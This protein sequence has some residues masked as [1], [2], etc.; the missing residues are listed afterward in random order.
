MV[1]AGLPAETCEGGEIEE[2]DFAVRSGDDGDIG[3]N[4]G[5]SRIDFGEHGAGGEGGH[6]GDIAPEIFLLNESGSAQEQTKAMDLF[7]CPENGFVL[8]I[9]AF[10][11][12]HA[13]HHMVNLIFGYAQ[14]EI[15]FF[16]YGKIF[17]IFDHDLVSYVIICFLNY[18]PITTTKTL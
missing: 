5:Q 17:F 9:G 11:R 4:L 1:A 14:K 7:P 6:D 3:R 16:E 8:L 2:H 12:I 15:R 13:G 18:I 10:L